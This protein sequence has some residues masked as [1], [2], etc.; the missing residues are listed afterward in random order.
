MRIIHVVWSLSF[1]GAETLLVQLLN[2]QCISNNVSLIIVNDV[3]ERSL[4][5]QID[6]KVRIIRINRPSK[7]RN[8]FYLLKLSWK[9]LFTKSDIV[10]FHQDNLIEYVP[11][12]FFKKNLCLTV[13]S[14][15]LDE[16]SLFKYHY[17]F[18]ISKSV[19]KRIKE[20]CGLD[21]TLIYNGINTSAFKSKEHSF[22]KEDERED[23][24][25][26]KKEDEKY[27]I[28]QIGR[29]NHTIKG[30]DLL[31][32]A[33]DIL[34]KKGYS[35]LS[36]SIIGDGI[37]SGHLQSLIDELNLSDYVKLEGSKSVSEIGVSLHH[38]DLLVQPSR[39][40]GFGLVAAEAMIAK[41]PV[42]VSDVAGLT[43]IIQ[44]NKYG[45]SFQSENEADF[46]N[47]IEQLISLSEKETEELANRAY[48]Y[49]IENFD[50]SVTSAK[51]LEAYKN[52]SEKN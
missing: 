16:K 36:V 34:V 40:E 51:Y 10:H 13:H 26:N 2:R 52:I 50:I 43:E 18:A 30:Q 35:D 28:V 27:K 46:A 42:L 17:L 24:K 32:K 9:L 12:R 25:E 41:V 14:V 39:Y 29:L 11:I 19:Q 21:S 44:E 7:N 5:E 33:V 4:L 31:I 48:Q 38:Y 1:G 47:K 8:P 23:E 15:S 22:K 45:F 6:K 3:I 49:V 37:S 20:S